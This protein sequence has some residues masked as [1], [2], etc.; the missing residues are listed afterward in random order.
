M[1]KL[2]NFAAKLFFRHV[3][4]KWMLSAELSRVHSTPAT[5]VGALAHQDAI[6]RRDWSSSPLCRRIFSRGG[7]PLPHDLIRPTG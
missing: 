2:P 5:Q 1:L 6:G 3:L 7:A 4:L